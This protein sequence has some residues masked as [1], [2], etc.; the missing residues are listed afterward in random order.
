MAR[1][2]LVT[3]LDPHTELAMKHAAQWENQSTERLEIN[4]PLE[5]LTPSPHN[6]RRL[7]LDHA[8]ID[9]E[10]VLVLAKK[11]DE[12]IDAWVERLESHIK[13]VEQQQGKKASS[14][15]GSLVDLS[16][17]LVEGDLLQPIVA[18]EENIIIAGER[19]WL[20]SLLAGLI[21]SRVIIRRMDEVKKAIAQFVENT[22]RSALSLAEEV[23][24][25][26]SLLALITGAPCSPENKSITVALCQQL[27]GKGRTQAWEYSMFARLP[28][29][30]VVLERIR[31]GAYTRKEEAV[32]AAQACLGDMRKANP[33][34][35]V[36]DAT[37]SPSPDAVPAPQKGAAKA[38]AG[39]TVKVRLPGT[40]AGKRLLQA[41]SAIP[42][43]PTEVVEQVGRVAQAWAEAPD[44]A[45][46]KM[47]TEVLNIIVDGMEPLEDS[48][49]ATDE[50]SK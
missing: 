25:L 2:K 12:S 19:R 41:V 11:P 5:S 14:T 20:A 37:D 6:P 42:E 39:P 50:D 32:A 15:W 21:T 4:Y 26:R 49:T 28:D 10:A 17:Q 45:R 9:R 1:R 34:A 7:T 47:L 30:H 24:G 48:D 33:T 44:K 40:E 31:A 46:K 29:D 13:Q 27:M 36:T 35:V 3:T 23:F 18:S 16:M 38:P 43:L 8:G 22:Q